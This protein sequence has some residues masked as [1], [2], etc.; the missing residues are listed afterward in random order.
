[1]CGVCVCVCVVCV[2][3]SASVAGPCLFYSAPTPFEV[4]ALKGGRKTKGGC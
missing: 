1:M 4:A 3:A 2:F